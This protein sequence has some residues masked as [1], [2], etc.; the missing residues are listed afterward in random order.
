VAGA[1]PAAAVADYLRTIGGADEQPAVQPISSADIERL[2]GR[3]RF[4]ASDDDEIR[5]ADAKGSLTFTRTGRVER[6]LSHVG[7]LE[8]FP[9]GVEQARV[10]FTPS[11]EG[12]RLTV[13]DPDVVLVAMKVAD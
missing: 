11:A 7:G 2:R 3:Y 13:T 9:A 5:I 12:L 10:V 8:F 6:F 4:G 1:A